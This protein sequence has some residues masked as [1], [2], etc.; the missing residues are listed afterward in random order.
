MNDI[1]VNAYCNFDMFI[2]KGKADRKLL[3]QLQKDL[4]FSNIFILTNTLSAGL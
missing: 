4:N 3:Q 1:F 2:L